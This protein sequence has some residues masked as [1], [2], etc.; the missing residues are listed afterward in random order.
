MPA[1]NKV[2]Y[3]V[4]FNHT[5]YSMRATVSTAD[6]VRD[7]AVQIL[8][9]EGAPAVTMRRVAQSVNI[10]PMAIYH[11]FPSRDALLT[12]ITEAEFAKLRDTMEAR[13]A[14]SDDADSLFLLLEAYI[15]YFFAHPHLFDYVFSK[16]RPD[17]R[18]F[19][20]DFHAGQSPPLTLLADSVAG[21]M[22]SGRLKDGDVWEIALEL[23][24]LIHGYIALYRAGRFHLSEPDFRQLCHRAFS[25]LLD[26]LA[27]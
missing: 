7:S 5:M 3:N 20:D 23:W 17:A 13:W 14:H 18:R 16:P 2:L 22:I 10:S 12:T 27:T 1:L 24:A 4:L 25:R 11:Y 21:S 26:G 15:D 9:Q 8:E 19:P 6:Q